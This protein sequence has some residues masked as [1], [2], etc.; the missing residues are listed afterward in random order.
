MSI[1]TDV[2]VTTLPPTILASS[3]CLN[4]TVACLGS[5]GNLGMGQLTGS[6]FFF[7]LFRTIRCGIYQALRGQV[8]WGW[9][10]SWDRMTRLECPAIFL[11][12]TDLRILEQNRRSNRG[13]SIKRAV[14]AGSASGFPVNL[15]ISLVLYLHHRPSRHEFLVFSGRASAIPV[16]SGTRTGG[17]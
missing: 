3:P 17:G 4:R 10:I 6:C 5:Y 1:F 16:R 9:F 8:V 12:L 7:F 13:M 15:S 14:V 11:F 2:Y